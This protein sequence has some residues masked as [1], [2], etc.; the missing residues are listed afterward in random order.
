[1]RLRSSLRWSRRGITAT[2]TGLL[3]TGEVTPGGDPAGSVSSAIGQGRSA[4][5]RRPGQD[6]DCGLVDSLAACGAIVES[7]MAAAGG[8]A[9]IEGGAAT[10]GAGAAP[11]ASGATLSG[12]AAARGAAGAT[13]GAGAAAM[14][15]AGA[16][17]EAVATGAGAAST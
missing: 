9:T 6:A 10:I 17:V 11:I 8:G 15:A 1:M 14:T 2:S 16:T 7:G 12:A 3:A 4:C 13:S 5:V